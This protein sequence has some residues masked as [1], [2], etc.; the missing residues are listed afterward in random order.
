[1][2]S[3]VAM[4]GLRGV[5]DGQPDMGCPF[6]VLLVDLAEPGGDQPAL[7]AGALPRS[8]WLSISTKKEKPI[9]K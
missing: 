6:N 1:M 4:L 3:L 7:G 9:A 5:L 2:I 8:R